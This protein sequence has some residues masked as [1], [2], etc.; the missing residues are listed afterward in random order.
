MKCIVLFVSLI[1]VVVSSG[2][3]AKPEVINGT[4]YGKYPKADIIT[5]S[6]LKYGNKHLLVMCD[7]TSKMRAIIIWDKTWILSADSASFE[8]EM[9]IPAIPCGAQLQ[10]LNR[11]A[12]IGKQYDKK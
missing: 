10:E 8:D 7:Q 12:E 4:A 9:E 6:K 1:L 5:Q 11:L 3:N 2:C